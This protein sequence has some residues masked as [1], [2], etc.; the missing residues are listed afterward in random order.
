MGK[1][2]KSEIRHILIVYTYTV[3]TEYRTK[4]EQKNSL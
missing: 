1:G 2:V 4:P 3:L